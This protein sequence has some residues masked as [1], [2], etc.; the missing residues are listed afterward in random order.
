MAAAVEAGETRAASSEPNAIIVAVP[1]TNP[2]TTMAT[3]F[4]IAIFGMASIAGRVTRMTLT[5]A[6]P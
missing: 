2:S 4:G 5:T 6:T 1:S 3:L